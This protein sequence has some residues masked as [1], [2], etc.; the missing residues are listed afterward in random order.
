MLQPENTKACACIQTGP[1]GSSPKAESNSAQGK[2]T[3]SVILQPSKHEIV[4]QQDEEYCITVDSCNPG[5]NVMHESGRQQYS[6]KNRNSSAPVEP[7]KEKIH[8]RQHQDSD[9][10]PREAPPKGCHAEQ[11]DAKSEDLFSER[12][13][14]NLIRP[15]SF[16]VLPGCSG[17][18]DL[19]KIRRVLIV[20]RFRY[21]VCLISECGDG[22][23]SC[24]RSPCHILQHRL[25]E[26]WRARGAYDPDISRLTGQIQLDI[27]PLQ[28]SHMILVE[29]TQRIPAFRIVRILNTVVSLSDAR[30]QY[31][32]VWHLICGQFKY[33]A[34]SFHRSKGLW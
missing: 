17:M 7:L 9:T 21:T 22:R 8:H 3:E 25:S 11:E 33:C 34:A 26:P 1:F 2:I 12:R 6:S 23:Y 16:Q 13:M 4:H 32:A 31:Q 10:S 18:V 15:D 29:C 30:K 24:D 14:R 27:L 28:H 19:V 20:H 5:L